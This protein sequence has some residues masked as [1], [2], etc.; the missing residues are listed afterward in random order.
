MGARS[1]AKSPNIVDEMVKHVQEN[2]LGATFGALSDPTRRAIVE[3]LT[4]GEA[5]V[6]ELAEP[7]EMSLPA[8]SKHLTVL[9]EAGLLTR[10]KEGRVRHCELV[11]EPLRDALQWIATYGRFWEDQLDSLE[12]FV[13]QSRK[14]R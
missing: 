3:R 8:V 12:K 11:E 6:G 7:F 14:K 5:T 2:A 13:A 9:E 4:E 1:A 10:T